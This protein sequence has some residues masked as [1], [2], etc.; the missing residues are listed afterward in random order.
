MGVYAGVTDSY[1]T[2]SDQ[3]CIRHSTPCSN[4]IHMLVLGSKRPPLFFGEE[5]G[6]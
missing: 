5:N 3:T 1:L 6:I 4:S 2:Q